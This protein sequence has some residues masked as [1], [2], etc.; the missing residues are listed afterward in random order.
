MVKKGLYKIETKDYIRILD[1]YKTWKEFDA[2]MREYSSRGVNLH[3]GISETIV[4]YV[5]DF[6]HS[7]GKGSEDAVTNDGKLVQVKATSNF[8]D[9]LT[10]FGPTSKFDL[11]HFARLDK[12]DDKL[13]LYDIPIEELYEVPVNENEKFRDKQLKGQRPRFSIIKKY[14][15]EDKERPYAIVDLI[16]GNIKR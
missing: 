14:L 10:S 13:Y 11:L 2:I 8:N 5:N 12:V 6:Y 7:V 9:D 16:T 3:E 15:S 4:C 1:A